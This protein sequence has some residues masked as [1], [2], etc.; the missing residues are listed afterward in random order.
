MK[1]LIVGFFVG[2]LMFLVQGNSIAQS[3][4]PVEIRI[5]N[6][7]SFEIPRNWVVLSENRTI[8]LNSYLKSI[9]YNPGGVVFQ[10]NLKNADGRPITTVQVYRWQSELHQTD[11]SN[12]SKNDLKI[13]ENGIFN[14]TKKELSQAGGS[15]SEW[16]GLKKRVINGL[17]V[18]LF[19]Y[20]RPSI[21]PPF[22]H[23]RVQV[24]R[25]Y[26]GDRSFS[27]VIS[28]HEETPFPLRNVVNQ[29]ITTLR[30]NGCG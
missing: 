18:L 5:D 14:Q 11:I 3:N 24:A 28:Y 23:F 4:G 27:F 22:G 21:L 10:A 17:L 16:Y 9:F 8:D 7:V 12:L 15:I 20:S 1:K 13:F 6:D 26:S 25:V 19:E 29:I 2:L 30:C